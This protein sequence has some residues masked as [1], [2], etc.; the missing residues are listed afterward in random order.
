VEIV[1]W[2]DGMCNG[3]GAWI[4]KNSWGA[5]WGGLG[6]FFYIQWGIARIGS[7]SFQI[8]YIFHRPR[9][10][11]LNYG[12]N[13]Q[14]GGNGNGRAEAGEM[15][16]LDFT[17]KNLWSA[18]GNVRVTV[19]AD[20]TGI[21]ITDNYSYLGNM[22]SK[23]IKNN[24]SDPMQFQVP[25][26][27][28]DRRVYFTFHVSG[29]SGAGVTY[30]ADTTVMVLVGRNILLVDDDQGVDSLGTNFENYYLNAF[31]SL[32]AVYDVWDKKT[33]PD[34]TF[35][36]SDFDVLIWF[37]GNHRDSVFSHT[38]IESLMTYLDDGGRLFL[39][40]QDAVEVLSNSFDPW[41]TLFL[42]NYLHVGFDGNCGRYMIVGQPGDEVGDTLY[43][44]PNYAVLNQTSM[45]NL[46]PDPES[47]PVLF[48]TL[49]TGAGWWTPTDSVAGTK[50]FDETLGFK[51]VVF[52]FGFESIRA[53]GGFFHGK[54]CSWPHFVMKR[55]LDW[56]KLPNPSI[57]VMAPNGGEG[58]IIGSTYDITWQSISFTDSVK[59]EY[60]TDAGANWITEAETTSN[61]GV[62]SWTIPPPA[63]DSCSDSC[64]VRISDVGNEKPVDHSDSCFSIINFVP[65]DCNGDGIVDLGDVVC[66]INYL[67]KGYPAPNPLAACDVNGDCVVDLG[68]A[69]YLITYLYKNGPAPVGRC[70]LKT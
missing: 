8:N 5:G 12:V 30:T 24:S 47:D 43:I 54:Y 16:R 20:T 67:Y 36:F 7:Y 25:H 49:S 45:D 70:C 50:Y 33:H 61:D 52:G 48:Y 11:L 55:V 68:D 15:C 10:R 38:D 32:K 17:L 59:I 28:P 44:V 35:K 65:G 60:S 62:Y 40:S 34:T 58:W 46:A 23:D 4:V 42:K 22:A 19:T 66:L 14:T 1:G 64:L 39:T 26:D 3:Q 2:D 27:F 29:D 37:T 63:L 13:D 53:D 57:S 18:L 56:L 31:D 21:I 9:V 6:G 51:V 41:D 69:V